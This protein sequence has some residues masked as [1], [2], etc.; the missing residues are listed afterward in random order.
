MNFANMPEL[1]WQFGYP[2]AILMMFGSAAGTYFFF[3]RKGLVIV[4]TARI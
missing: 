3:K 4:E 1:D 2:M